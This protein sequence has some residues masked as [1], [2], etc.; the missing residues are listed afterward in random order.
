MCSTEE[1]LREYLSADPKDLIA[2]STAT[3][4][5]NQKEANRMYEEDPS[6]FHPS[7]GNILE[8]SIPTATDLTYAVQANRSSRQIL[9]NINSSMPAGFFS[10]KE[11]L[12]E[13]ATAPSVSTFAG[14]VVPVLPTFPIYA[15]DGTEFPRL[16]FE[17]QATPAAM[18][19]AAGLRQKGSLFG[20]RVFDGHALRTITTDHGID[21]LFIPS[22]DNIHSTQDL[23]LCL[24]H[25]S[26]AAH[27]GGL[28][29]FQQLMDAHVWWPTMRADAF[30]FARCC[31]NCD[32]I[33]GGS[34]Y[35]AQG[36]LQPISTKRVSYVVEADVMGPLIPDGPS[37]LE[38]LYRYIIVIVDSW[39]GYTMLV[40][41]ASNDQTGFR[42]ALGQWTAIFGW[43]TLL[44]TDGGKSLVAKSVSELI[45]ANG[46]IRSVST[47]ITRRRLAETNV[48]NTTHK[49]QSRS[50]LTILNLFFKLFFK[51]FLKFFLKVSA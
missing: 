46:S 41:C 7:F 38:K 20:T 14:I 33:R 8:T 24:A 19:E 6:A 36:S 45:S 44:Y 30:A 21:A 25:K 3:A 51:V 1:Q 12:G 9:Q 43:P 4:L 32:R 40:P 11:L 34:S 26:A 23:L 10:T 22:D 49:Q 27:F 39:S 42:S 2:A 31:L 17:H 37:P 16:L 29:T 13:G 18:D 47:L 15:V 28:R 35:Y 48:K 5:A 50:A